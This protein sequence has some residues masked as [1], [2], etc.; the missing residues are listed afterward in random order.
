MRIYP[1]QAVM[2]RPECAQEVASPPY[3][4][5]SREEANEM[6]SGNPRSFLRILRS[7]IDFPSD[8]DPY[9]PE[10]YQQARQNYE[11][12][13]QNNILIKDNAPCFYIYSMVMDG[14]RQTGLAV[15][16]DVEDYKSNTI[17]KHEKTRPD[18]EDDRTRHILAL[19]AQTG[20]VFLTCP[21]HR[22]LTEL[23][24]AAMLEA[25]CIDFTAADGIKHSVWRISDSRISEFQEL[26]NDFPALYIAD[27]HHRAAAAAR[28]ANEIRTRNSPDNSEEN[29]ECTR[30]PTVVFPAGQLRIFSYNRVVQDL[31]GYSPENFRQMLAQ[32]FTIE[33]APK[34]VPEKQGDIHMYLEGEWLRLRL[35][36]DKQDKLG[37]SPVEQLD[38][39]CL[40]QLVLSPCLNIQDPRTD[41]RI[42]FVGG[43][44]G[45]EELEKRV[46]TG[47]ATVAFYMYPTTVDELMSIAEN[48]SEMPPKSTWFEPKLRDGLL[49]HE[50]GN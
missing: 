26:F 10:V 38:V 4:V 31:N 44:R 22:R 35:K 14:Q 24:E 42:D 36:K 37:D 30:F 20:L 39:N 1:F 16:C 19:N 21:D 43:I 33:P 11:N 34:P 41:K 6:A 8:V 23:M 7:E 29:E 47:K 28:A 5:V 40:Q 18:K 48:G 15:T 13:R 50:F 12:L 25:P 45:Y 27:G 32:D 17:R 9:S 3:D 49:V 2:P 46:D